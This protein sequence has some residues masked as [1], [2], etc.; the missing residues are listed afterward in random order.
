MGHIRKNDFP[1]PC[2]GISKL[3]F[4]FNSVQYGWNDKL[5]R[6]FVEYPDQLKS[7]TQS[8]AV[9]VHALIGNM[10]GYIGLFLGKIY[11]YR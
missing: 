6:I 4:V 11:S 7:I 1:P 5:L 3:D 2:Q 9:D 10:G 8:Q